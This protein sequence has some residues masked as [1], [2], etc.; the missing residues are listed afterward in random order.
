MSEQPHSSSSDLLRVDVEAELRC[1]AHEQM[2]GVWQ[3]P[4]E[5]IRLLIRRGAR[6]LEV[7]AK[8]QGVRLGAVGATLDHDELATLAVA[9][10]PTRPA[11]DRHLA[12]L[13][14][15]SAGAIE[16][17]WATGA[18]ESG[19]HTVATSP[20]GGLTLTWRPGRPPVLETSAAGKNAV[21]IELGGHALEQGRVVSWLREACRFVRVPLAIDGMPCAIGLADPIARTRLVAPL[22]AEVALPRTG[23]APRLWLMR[24]SV[25]VAH[26]TVPGYPCFQ[27]A[28]ELGDHVPVGASAG[29]AREAVAGFIPDLIGAASELAITSTSQLPRLEAADA[30][31]IG[32]FLLEC[33]AVGGRAQEIWTLAA[34]PARVRPAGRD[35]VIWLSLAQVAERADAVPPAVTALPPDQDPSNFAL[36]AEPTLILGERDHELVNQ[37]IGRKLRPPAATAVRSA[38]AWQRARRAIA[39]RLRALGT[40]AFRLGAQPIPDRSLEPRERAFLALLAGI[41]HRPIRL[42]FCHGKGRPRPARGE[43]LLPRASALVQ[44]GLTATASGPGW[45]YPAALALLGERAALDPTARAT[46]LASLVDYEP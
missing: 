16:L 27:A 14:L 33:A 37:L 21:E 35:S 31:R 30:A 26:A 9:L 7:W 39:S 18:A 20:R 25:V 19:L 43:L 2:Q 40:I 41:L 6:S 32:R 42:R 5:L 15:E 11:A 23:S 13:A 46:W 8:R 10:D 24:D 36:G 29:Q 38:P 34:L 22:R 1:L 17:L 4:A 44:T 12:L 3:A 45:R 28:V